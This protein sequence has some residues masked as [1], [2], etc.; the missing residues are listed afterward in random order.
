ML[1]R[2]A[3]VW[4]TV[5]IA[6]AFPDKVEPCC[7]STQAF[8]VEGREVVLVPDRSLGIDDAPT[9]NPRWTS[10]L[11]KAVVNLSIIKYVSLLRGFASCQREGWSDVSVS[12]HLSL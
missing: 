2:N 6:R 4:P 11:S 12:N 7:C 9:P 8:Y 10:L 5:D 1:W 3:A